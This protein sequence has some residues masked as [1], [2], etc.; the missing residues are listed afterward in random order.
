M[1]DCIARGSTWLPT[2]QWSATMA[3][4]NFVRDE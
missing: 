3:S 1:M 2:D 4:Q